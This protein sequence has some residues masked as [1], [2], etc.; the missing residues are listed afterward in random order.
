MC[1]SEYSKILIGDDKMILCREKDLKQTKVK[2]VIKKAFPELFAGL[3]DRIFVKIN[4]QVVCCY[5]MYSSQFDCQVGSLEKNH[6][7]DIH[8]FM[9]LKVFEKD[10][11]TYCSAEPVVV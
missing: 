10:G 11:K 6:N 8:P 3:I 2:K 9:A 4:Y 5:K 1:L 7:W